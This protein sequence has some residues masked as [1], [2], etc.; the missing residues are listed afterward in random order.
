MALMTQQNLRPSSLEMKYL[1]T[2]LEAKY[3]PEKP[4]ELY[5]LPAGPLPCLTLN[6]SY[7]DSWK[8]QEQIHA[9]VRRQLSEV[10]I[11]LTIRNL[12][13]LGRISLEVFQFLETLEM[14][15]QAVVRYIYDVQGPMLYMD[16]SVFFVPEPQEQKCSRMPRRPTGPRKNP[17]SIRNLTKSKYFSE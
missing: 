11:H 3:G 8:S 4:L 9:F 7:F 10:L 16:Q 17:V 6:K 13:P 1:G 5:A 2:Y 14:P 15:N 12:R